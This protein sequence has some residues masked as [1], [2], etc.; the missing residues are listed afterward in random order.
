MTSI[1]KVLIVTDLFFYEKLLNQL[2]KNK[3]KVTDLTDTSVL[4]KSSRN[5]HIVILDLNDPLVGGF[6]TI[7]KF[8]ENYQGKIIVF[9]GHSQKRILRQAKSLDVDKIT[10]NSQILSSIEE[11]IRKVMSEGN[12]Y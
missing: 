12:L 2:P 4:L 8:K 11:I 9:A 3:Y 10:K 5:F 6:D 7:K 1:V